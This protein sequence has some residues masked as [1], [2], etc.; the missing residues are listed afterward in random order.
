[1]DK[2]EKLKASI[3]AKSEHPFR[4]IKRKFGFIKGRFEGLAKNA[5]QILTLFELSNN[6]LC[7]PIGT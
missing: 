6:R 1:L 2:A 5:A 3:R 4:V 7:T